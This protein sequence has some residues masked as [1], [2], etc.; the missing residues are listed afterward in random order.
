M[1]HWWRKP[2]LRRD[3]ELGLQRKATWLELFYDLVFVVVVAQLAHTLVGRVDWGDV[4][5]YAPMFVPAWWLW[6]AGTFYA[7]R[8]EHDDVSHRIMVFISMVPVAALAVFT[9][10]GTGAT[11]REFGLA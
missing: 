1:S 8:F 7:E 5:S 6:I 11:S 4:G 9:H 2:R 3:A 10:A